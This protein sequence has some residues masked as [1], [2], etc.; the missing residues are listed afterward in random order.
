[1]T[2]SAAILMA[3]AFQVGAE[4]ARPTLPTGV[5]VTRIPHDSGYYA[6]GPRARQ[7]VAEAQRTVVAQRSPGPDGV[8]IPDRSGAP[9]LV[10]IGP[11]DA[12]K[13][14]EAQ[15]PEDLASRVQVARFEPTDPRL[16]RGF[17]RY[18][19]GGTHALI[20]EADRTVAWSG[21]VDLAEIVHHLRRL[22]GLE[23]DAPPLFPDLPIPLPSLGGSPVLL[24]SLAFAG[25]L[26]AG[27]LLR[28]IGRRLIRLVVS[29]AKDAIRAAVAEA[30]RQ[31]TPR[32][33]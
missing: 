15:I 20:L 32:P 19:Q 17:K 16:D 6:V 9:W 13:Q 5:D 21:L 4:P 33:N 29:Q 11:D 8:D 12:T 31:E 26:F 23:P 25:G 27:P 1:M 2:T 18:Y 22:L 3:L 14:A 30:Q 24:P 28:S 10:L 7:W